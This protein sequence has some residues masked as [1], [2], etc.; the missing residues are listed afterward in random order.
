MS[1]QNVQSGTFPYE[2]EQVVGALR[3]LT[4]KGFTHPDDLPLDDPEVISANKLLGGWTQQQETAAK[5]TGTLEAELEYSLDMS[6][7]LV[8]AGFSDPDYLDEV[9]HDLLAQDLQ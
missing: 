9:A 2:R 5:T 3:K 1:D 7:I 6:T 8:D 4:A